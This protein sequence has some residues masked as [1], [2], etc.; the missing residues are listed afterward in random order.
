MKQE[1]IRNEV[2][3]G[4]REKGSKA[5]MKLLKQ[6]CERNV[7][8]CAGPLKDKRADILHRDILN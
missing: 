6:L 4:K 7:C 1:N 3:Q 5:D 2:D 8:M